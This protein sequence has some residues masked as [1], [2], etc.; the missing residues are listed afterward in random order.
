MGSARSFQLG[1]GVSRCTS[2]SIAR[3][4]QPCGNTAPITSASG[5][6]AY[7]M[8]P[9]D[10]LASNGLDV[11]QQP[12][13][14]QN[15][16]GIGPERHARPHG[17]GRGSALIN[18]WVVALLAQ[19][20]CHAQTCNAAAQYSDFH[21]ESLL[22]IRCLAQLPSVAPSQNGILDFADSEN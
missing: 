11:L 13:L 7:W 18:P 21:V 22:S 5:V 15:K 8:P 1:D 14:F 17:R 2:S 9:P 20:Q 16:A 4:R 12:Q 10:W 3:L 6:S 19:S